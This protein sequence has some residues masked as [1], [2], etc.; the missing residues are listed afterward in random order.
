MKAVETAL[1]MHY[2]DGKLV[3][4]TLAFLGV[5][6]LPVSVNIVLLLVCVASMCVCEHRTA[7]HHSAARCG[8]LMML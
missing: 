2:R 6:G 5:C 8:D 1:Q 3:V 7:A 4:F